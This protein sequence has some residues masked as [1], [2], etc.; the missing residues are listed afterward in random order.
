MPGSQTTLPERVLRD[1][2]AL[3]LD[4]CG[5]LTVAGCPSCSLR[6]PLSHLP[7]ETTLESVLDEREQKE[8]RLCHPPSPAVAGT[9]A[10]DAARRQHPG[11]RHVDDDSLEA[12]SYLTLSEEDPSFAPPA[13]S[14]DGGGGSQSRA[15][16]KRLRK[17]MA[18]KLARENLFPVRLQQLDWAMP[19]CGGVC[20]VLS[21]GDEGMLARG[22]H[23]GGHLPQIWK[24][25]EDEI[26]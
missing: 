25:E 3:T 1:G 18:R 24:V 12:D 26:Y 22:A 11:A 21:P 15:D 7:A 14:G 6:P 2:T 10:S 16:A 20:A 9:D 8:Q 19:A 17:E 5:P 13:G 23:K 4:T